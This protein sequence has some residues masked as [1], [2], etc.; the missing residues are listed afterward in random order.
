MTL[1]PPLSYLDL[2]LLCL[3]WGGGV[4]G[5]GWDERLGPRGWLFGGDK[6]GRVRV[7]VGVGEWH[8]AEGR[9]PRHRYD[10]NLDR[11]VPGRAWV[12]S[13]SATPLRHC[14]HYIAFLP[15]R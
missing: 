6:G 4:R 5:G 11:A 9:I 8:G 12:E 1:A 10:R 13:A 14:K 2:S 7:G 15:W 3:G